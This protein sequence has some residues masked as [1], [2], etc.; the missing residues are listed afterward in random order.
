MTNLA[1]QQQTIG[2]LVA[3]V[4]FALG[5]RTDLA[6][7]CSG[8]LL[9]SYRELGNTVPL[10]TLEVEEAD[11]MVP[12]QTDYPYP[13]TARALKDL[14][15]VVGNS[16]QPVP[17]VK[18]D[19]RYIDRYPTN[20]QGVPSVWSPFNRVAKVRMPP[21]DSYSLIWEFWAFPTVDPNVTNN[22]VLLVP[23]DWLEVVKYGA[24]MRGWMDLQDY[25]K[26]QAI[27]QILYGD[28]V[29][30]ELPGLIKEKLLQQAAENVMSDYAVAPK[31]RTYTS[32]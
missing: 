17:L 2:G 10:E 16:T 11:V 21:S 22:T 28:P 20:F 9:D 32:R 25:T 7:Q 12:G 13:A 15:I 29:R 30:P 23:D 5:N 31:I 8:W 1:P 6:T 4:T 26:A 27:R 24:T 14:Y 18:K 3:G 19:I